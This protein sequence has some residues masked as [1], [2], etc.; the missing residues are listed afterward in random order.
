VDGD[1]QEYGRASGTSAALELQ[2]GVQQNVVPP[3]SEVPPP[4]QSI[5]GGT[6]PWLQGEVGPGHA[7]ANWP[8]AHADTSAL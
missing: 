7:Y 3:S 8:A 5:H 2:L 6:I 1:P 4:A